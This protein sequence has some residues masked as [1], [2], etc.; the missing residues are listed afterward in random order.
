MIRSIF[1]AVLGMAWMAFGAYAPLSAPTSAADKAMQEAL[2][3][4]QN[5]GEKVQIAKSA[6]EANPEDVILGKSV[7]MVL[8][9]YMPDAE[10]YFKQR[11]AGESIT[12]RYLYAWYFGDSSTSAKEAD[13]IL[14]KDPK[15]FWGLILAANAE[16]D[17]KNADMGKVTSG[18]QAAIAA[19]PSQP[20][21]YMLLGYAYEDMQKWPDAR[22]AFEAGAV[23]DASNTEIRDARLT[24]YAQLRESDAYFKLASGMFPADPIALDLPYAKGSQHLTAATLQGKTTVLEFWG[25]S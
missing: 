4:A 14:K 12:S 11:A 5:D 15:N 24:I 19:D 1:V 13:W 9:K 25:F 20:D 3:K 6:F 23:C 2:S 21:G 10:N 16:W 7:A 18:L 22:E 17:Q 8:R